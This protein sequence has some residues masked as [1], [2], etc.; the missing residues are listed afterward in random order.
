MHILRF[1][2]QING[3][4]PIYNSYHL[5]ART[6]S[7]DLAK[8]GPEEGWHSNHAVDGQVVKAGSTLDL[9]KGTTTADGNYRN[10]Y[11]MMGT[12]LISLGYR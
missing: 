11:S 6:P 10:N 8:G 9:Y 3:K 4:T 5:Y 7:T 12:Q 1:K 2:Q